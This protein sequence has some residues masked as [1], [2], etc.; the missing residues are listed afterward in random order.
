MGTRTPTRH[1]R[2]IRR[3]GVW[4]EA[5]DDVV[6]RREVGEPEVDRERPSRRE[7]DQKS[8]HDNGERPE[9]QDVTR[10]RNIPL[11]RAHALASH[12][13]EGGGPEHGRDHRRGNSADENGLIPGTVAVGRCEPEHD[14]HQPH[15]RQLRPRCCERD[16][17]NEQVVLPDDRRQHEGGGERERER[18]RI[19]ATPATRQQATS[20]P[21]ARRMETGS[22]TPRPSPKASRTPTTE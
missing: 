15:R 11:H 3:R 6:R 12:R 20:S 5:V 1:R 19:V 2:R 14:R 9:E 10:R 17:E 22:A 8:A 13:A 21:A 7:P 18:A 4:V 16:D